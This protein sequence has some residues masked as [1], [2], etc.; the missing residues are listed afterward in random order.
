[1]CA[2]LNGIVFSTKPQNRTIITNWSFIHKHFK[3]QGLSL[4]KA[5]LK[6][7]AQLHHSA[8]ESAEHKNVLKKKKVGILHIFIF[9]TGYPGAINTLPCLKIERLS[10]LFSLSNILPVHWLTIQQKYPWTSW[11][12][13]NHIFQTLALVFNIS[14]S[15]HLLF[16][17]L[18]EMK[19][20]PTLVPL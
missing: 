4:S 14:L 20:V 10:Q 9:V 18:Q 13:H 5:A 1:M 8:G 2:V 19:P 17:M 11:Q 3:S 7:R 12:K 15:N 6:C 16:S